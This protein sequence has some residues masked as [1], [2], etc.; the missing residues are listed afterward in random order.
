MRSQVTLRR[1][2]PTGRNAASLWQET[3]GAV[4]LEYGLIAALIAVALIGTITQL[5][6]SLFGLPLQSLIDALIGAQS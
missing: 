4:A 1:A 2:R 6:E 3:S 5:G